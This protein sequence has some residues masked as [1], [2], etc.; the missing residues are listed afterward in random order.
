MFSEC[1]K[2]YLQLLMNIAQSQHTQGSDTQKIEVC[3]KHAIGCWR[4][5]QQLIKSN[6][7]STEEEEIHFFKHI[8]ARFTGLI[9]YYTYRYH[10]LL[11]MTSQDKAEQEEFWNRELRKIERFY[12][13]HR[14]FCQ[15][16]RQGATNKD[17][18]Y[19]LRASNRESAPLQAR[20]HDID[21]DT[22]TSHDHLL[23]LLNAYKLY[24]E[25]IN[26]ELRK[27][28]GYFFLTN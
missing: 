21:P 7:F 27:L 12:E 28:Q 11:F 5:V 9:E 17:K 24:K 13:S 25:H 4:K 16:I 19:F 2:L 14:E 8:K 1:P 20:I 22:S 3:F 18:D 6:D 23:T 26:L 10:A 15:Y